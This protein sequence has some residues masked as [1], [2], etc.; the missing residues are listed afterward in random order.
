MK[1]INH[2]RAHGHP[3]LLPPIAAACMAA[4][5]TAC[6]GDG[7]PA[8]GAHDD[9]LTLEIGQRASLLD[10]DRYGDGPAVAGAG[11][12]TVVSTD[13]PWPVGLTLADGVVEVGAEVV[14]GTQ[15]LA[16]LLCDAIE[17]TRCAG[18][19]LVLTVPP[20]AL[21]A[22]DD[23]F[24]LAPGASADVLA[25]DRLGT[26]AVAPDR[27]AVAATGN[28]PAGLTLSANGLLAVAA[29]AAAGRYPIGYR[30]CQTA[31]PANCAEATATVVVPGL[32]SVS[33]RVID[34]STAR[35]IAGARVSAAGATTTSDADGAY[36]LA[37]LAAGERIALRFSADAYADGVRIATVGGAGA[38]DATARLVPRGARSTI[39]PAA[40]ASVGPAGS[41]AS[42]VIAPGSL[43]LADGGTL[44]GAVSVALTA[45]DPSADSSVLPGDYSSLQ[46]AVV[47]LI[48]SFG[49]LEIA[50]QDASGAAVGFIAGAPGTVRIPVGTRSAEL[51]ASAVLYWFDVLAGRWQEAGTATLAGTDAARY[52]EGAVV[53]AGLWTA[54]RA[55]AT[56]RVSGCLVDAAGAPVAGGVVAADGIDYSGRAGALTDGAGHFD[57]D[58]RAGGRATLS[59]IGN[60]LASNTVSA[61]PAAADTTLGAC[62]VLGQQGA[63]VTM[64][65]TWGGRPSDLDA[66]LYAPDGSHVYFGQHGALAA[67]PFANLDID[68]T[69]SFGP[70]VV[71]IARLM[72][73][74]YAYAVHNYSGQAA[75]WI[76]ASGARIELTVPGRAQELLTPPGAGEDGSTDWWQVLQFDVDAACNVSVRRTQQFS[77]RPPAAPTGGAATY[78]T[79]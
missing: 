9:T 5:L 28:L 24:V 3:T 15:P 55:P 26:G 31:S 18:A 71:T 61:G 50:L 62:L 48:E 67:A 20:P 64:K 74:T 38:G 63:G 19:V 37:G 23:S 76:G 7:P 59:A 21:V 56:V 30:V 11:G 12:N 27:V 79:R 25:N 70:E 35:P 52:Y 77:A 72:V 47:A 1:P 16:Y 14:P 33:G 2:R 51:P 13:G 44:A 78:C 45:I 46:A 8:L 75:G 34:A 54:G 40:G 6:G 10:N 60:G 32:A 58:L 68:D 29:D 36:L 69:T 41:A 49:A 43:R 73:G 42:L 53:R 65:L 39:D 22:A 17:P 4:M 57:I 66:H